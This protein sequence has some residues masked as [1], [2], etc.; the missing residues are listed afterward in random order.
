MPSEDQMIKLKVAQPS[1][2]WVITISFDPITRRL[3]VVDR[4]LPTAR[5]GIDILREALK[6]AE[7]YAS[8]VGATGLVG[9]NGVPLVKEGLSN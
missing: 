7:Q 3:A 8:G 5:A 4:G 2:E 6:Y 1:T 9:P